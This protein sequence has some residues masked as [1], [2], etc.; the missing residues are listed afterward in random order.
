MRV[1]DLLMMLLP[2]GIVVHASNSTSTL[3]VAISVSAETHAAPR[4]TDGCPYAKP[5]LALMNDYH[6]IVGNQTITMAA[7]ETAHIVDGSTY[8]NPPSLALYTTVQ[9][10]EFDLGPAKLYWFSENKRDVSTTTSTFVFTPVSTSTSEVDLDVTT[11]TSTTTA[12]PTLI[13]ETETLTSTPVVVKTIFYSSTSPASDVPSSQPQGPRP[14]TATRPTGSDWFPWAALHSATP[15]A[16]GESGKTAKTA[17]YYSMCLLANFRPLPM[18]T[19]RRVAIT[20]VDYYGMP[21]SRIGWLSE[22]YTNSGAHFGQTVKNGLYYPAIPAPTTHGMETSVAMTTQRPMH[23]A[24]KSKPTN[25]VKPP[26]CWDFDSCCYE[27]RH[28][29]IHH[30]ARSG[31]WNTIKWVGVAVAALAT[32]L[33]LACCIPICVRRHRRRQIAKKVV[34]EKLAN[35]KLAS[36]PQQVVVTTAPGQAAP[37]TVVTTTDP[38]DGR[39]TLGR[40]AEEGRGQVNFAPGTGPQATSTPEVITT[41]TPAAENIIAVDPT[42]P[43]N[44]EKVTKTATPA[45]MEKSAEEKAANAAQQKAQVVEQTPVPV[46]DGAY[47]YPTSSQMADMGSMRGRKRKPDGRGNLLNL[48]F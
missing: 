40:R 3:D 21:T 14:P 9:A 12:T 15:T 34:N 5:T 39:G 44:A 22:E 10:T 28:P 16:C 42:A 18:T 48:G 31:L 45:D 13:V 32:L 47:D 11:T 30:A 36:Q 23:D 26:T 25:A 2:V 35:E 8:H 19:V 37:T 41:T 7:W 38:D 27:C 20:T 24:G 29:T 4:H 6:T 46:H 1:S 17:C 33:L 43:D